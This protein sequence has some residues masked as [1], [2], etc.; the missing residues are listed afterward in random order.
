M[1][2]AVVYFHVRYKL[3]IRYAGSPGSPETNE[4]S[5]S[6]I[7]S[8][9]AQLSDF[10]LAVCYNQPLASLRK[11]VH[12]ISRENTRLQPFTTWEY[13]SFNKCSGFSY[14]SNNFIS[15]SMT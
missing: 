14:V 15:T 9:S 4:P 7:C 13:L 11:H 10:R 1:N 3:H 6:S 12:Y 5:M 8:G 2:Y